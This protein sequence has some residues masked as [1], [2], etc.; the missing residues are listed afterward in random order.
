MKQHGDTNSFTKAQ[1]HNTQ[2]NSLQSR[3]I[4]QI[5]YIQKHSVETKQTLKSQQSN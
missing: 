2:K 5:N 1:K 3:S 4:C